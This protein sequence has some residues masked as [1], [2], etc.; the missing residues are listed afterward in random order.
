ME[1]TIKNI[2]GWTMYTEA[3]LLIITNSF[4]DI[5]EKII[6]EFIYEINKLSIILPNREVIGLISFLTCDDL[7][8]N[9]RLDK[10][11]NILS[12]NASH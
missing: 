8:Y 10:I 3:D 11:I 9:N 2:A 5:E 4:P 1:F 12:K 6:L 7:K